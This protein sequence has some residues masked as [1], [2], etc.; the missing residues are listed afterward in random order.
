VRSGSGTGSSACRTCGARLSRGGCATRRR[1]GASSPGSPPPT[2]STRRRRRSTASWTAPTTTWR[3]SS[4][5][6]LAPSVAPAAR[7]R[8]AAARHLPGPARPGARRPLS[9]PAFHPPE[10]LAS[11]VRAVR[12]G[13]DL[14]DWRGR[15]AGLRKEGPPRPAR[16]GPGAGGDAALM[17]TGRFRGRPYV[18]HVPDDYRGDE[19]F[20]L[21]VI[22]GAARPG[23]AHR[24]DRALVPRA[25]GVLAL[26]PGER[27][28]WEEE[29][30]AAV[31]ALLA[32]ALAE[33]NVD[34][35]RVTITGFSNGGTGSLLYAARIP[36]RFAAVASLMGGGLPFFEHD[37]V[38]DAAAIA[39]IP[40]L[41]VHGERRDHTG[42]G[43]RAHGEGDAEGEPRRGGRDA[44]A[45]RTA[46]RRRLRPGGRAR[47]PVPRRHVRDPFPRNVAMRTRTLDHPRAYW[48]RCWRRTAARPR[49]TARSRARRSLFGRRTCGSCVCCCGRT[50]RPRLSG[51]R[52]GG[53]PGGLRRRRPED[54]ALLLRSWRETGDP[55]SPTRPRSPST[56]VARHP[57]AHWSHRRE[58]PAGR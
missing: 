24:P 52:H 12:S 21:V 8:A 4:S 50:P 33:L 44:R 32:E 19:P 14:P 45:S 56:W 18:L 58:G 26:F 6:W 5:P 40:F 51:P 53:R 39:R 41:F 13:G 3:A 15:R 34:T 55:S 27:M 20:P 29:P 49:S 57:E 28:W 9:C 47:L 48:S 23:R 54:P 36:D 17:R 31:E 37:Q 1:S 25:L 46:S 35:D 2:V 7:G 42:R 43:E 30:G 16:D 11:L 10:P 22:L 38:I